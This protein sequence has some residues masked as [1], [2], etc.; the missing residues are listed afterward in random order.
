MKPVPLTGAGLAE[1]GD[2]IECPG[3][4]HFPIS[5]S[6]AVRHHDPAAADAATEPQGVDYARSIWNHPRPVFQRDND[7][8][9]VDR[10]CPGNDPDE[11]EFA[12][13]IRLSLWADRNCVPESGA[14]ALSRRHQAR[15]EY[16]GIH[17]FR[18]VDNRCKIRLRRI[19]LSMSMPGDNGAGGGRRGPGGSA[20]D[21]CRA[22]ER[23]QTA[24]SNRS[25][26]VFQDNA[27]QGSQNFI[28]S[29][30]ANKACDGGRIIAPDQ[31]GSGGR[32]MILELMAHVPMPVSG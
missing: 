30:D 27:F 31:I 16:A 4:E 5:K 20:R 32:L 1:F 8:L 15:Q 10:S 17:P 7:F 25:A 3:S 21:P 26:P 18:V 24:T 28:G 6:F 23:R 19:S 12:N 29:A 2:A 11:R 14:A 22:R 9:V 13:S